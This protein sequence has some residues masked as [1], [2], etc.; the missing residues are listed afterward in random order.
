MKFFI[1][2]SSTNNSWRTDR[3]VFRYRSPL[4]ALA[5]YRERF[6]GQSIAT[7]L[8]GGNIT[9]EHMRQWLPS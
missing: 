2:R 9:P 6:K 7:I 8:T 5:T 3:H 1:S 4:A